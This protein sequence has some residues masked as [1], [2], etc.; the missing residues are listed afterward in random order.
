LVKTVGDVMAP[1]PL[2]VVDAT[3]SIDEVARRMRAWDVR[4]VLVTFQGRLCGVLTDSDIVVLA[5]AAG[6]HPADILA[7]ECCDPDVQTVTVDTLTSSA[8]ELMRR[9]ALGRLPVI[10]A[11]RLVGTIWRSTVERAGADARSPSGVG[12]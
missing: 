12:G 6:R 2:T 1:A 9:D 8:A 4:E 5:I 3:T 7:G 11:E 10:D